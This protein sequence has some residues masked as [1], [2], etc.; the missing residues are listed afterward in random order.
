LKFRGRDRGPTTLSTAHLRQP[1][2][3]RSGNH[4]PRARSARWSQPIVLPR[5]AATP[6]GAIPF[7]REPVALGQASKDGI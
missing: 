5:R 3:R 7:R 1:D 6:R 2:G 4:L